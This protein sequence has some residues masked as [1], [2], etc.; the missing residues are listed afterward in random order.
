MIQTVYK[1]C[2]SKLRIIFIN[3]PPLPTPTNSPFFVTPGYSGD[4]VKIIECLYMNHSTNSP[5]F[6]PLPSLGTQGH[7]LG[8]VAST[9][10]HLSTQGL[11]HL[12]GK[13]VQT[14]LPAVA[15]YPAK[16]VDSC[17][18]KA[19]LDAGSSEFILRGHRCPVRS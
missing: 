8:A 1:V 11:Q 2:G 13:G 16:G 15:Q 4:R 9:V 17:L 3:H 18:V 10:L 6:V 14:F 5:R 7:E 19:S 12:A